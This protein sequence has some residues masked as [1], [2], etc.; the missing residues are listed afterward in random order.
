MEQISNR[1]DQAEEAGVR[2][3]HLQLAGAFEELRI[4]GSKQIARRRL[5]MTGENFMQERCGQAH[6]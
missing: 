4:G 2:H 1:L 3:P 6:R 5:G